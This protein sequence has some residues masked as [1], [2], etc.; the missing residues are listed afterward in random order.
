MSDSSRG[1]IM[2]KTPTVEVDEA[3]ASVACARRWM[4]SSP[5]WCSSRATTST[6]TSA[7]RSGVTPETVLAFS[8]PLSK[9]KGLALMLA[10][11][12]DDQFLS[13]DS[14]SSRSVGPVCFCITPLEAHR[15]R[16]RT[17]RVVPGSAPI[18]VRSPINPLESV[19]EGRSVWRT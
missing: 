7:R 12:D 8:R 17:L 11:P 15:K 19:D 14:G 4:S 3:K 13:S 18:R 10:N 6:R 16:R 2:A 9:R 5:T 1:Q